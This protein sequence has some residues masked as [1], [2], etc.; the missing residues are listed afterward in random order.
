MLLDIKAVVW[1]SQEVFLNWENAL[2]VAVY[3]IKASYKRFIM[4]AHDI[5]GEA[6]LCV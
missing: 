2:E 5:F 4:T 6:S 1:F 3:I